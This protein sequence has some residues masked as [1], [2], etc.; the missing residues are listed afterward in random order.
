[1]T[2]DGVWIGDWIY[3]PLTYH[4]E[5]TSTY[6]ATLISTIHKSPQ[7]PLNFFQ[8]TVFTSR[9]LVTAS[10]RG[11]SSASVLKSSLHRLPYR[12]DFV[13]SIIFHTTSRHGPCGNNP[14][15]TVTL[16]LRVDSLPRE[17]EC[18]RFYL[19]TGL[20]EIEHNL[21]YLARTDK[22]PC[23]YCICIQ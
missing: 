17:R 12:T 23:I 1:V 10:N 19:V 6:S 3:W 15:P 9:S 14:F 8:P 11:D 16:L 13:A 21:L 18:F 5:R 20:P 2:I 7:R 4:S 22:R